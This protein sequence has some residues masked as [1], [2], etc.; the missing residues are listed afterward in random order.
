MKTP[1]IEE[2]ASELLAACIEATSLFDNY[3]ECSE[4]IGTYQVLNNAI[5][6]AIAYNVNPLNYGAVV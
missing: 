6:K 2:I 1:T 4:A 5:H 3:P